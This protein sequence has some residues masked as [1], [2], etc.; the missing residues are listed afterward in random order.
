MCCN[1][2][3]VVL[4]AGG[5]DWGSREEPWDVRAG[6]ASLCIS[7]PAQLAQLA[8]PGSKPRS[9]PVH[10]IYDGTAGTKGLLPPSCSPLRGFVFGVV[11]GVF[12]SSGGASVPGMKA[13]QHHN[14]LPVEMEAGWMDGR[15]MDKRHF[16]A[17]MDLE[18]PTEL[19]QL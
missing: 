6:R 18:V 4:G 2:A 12:T 5:L 16:L 9:S 17:W 1:E 13:V 3:V 10:F 19:L 7:R 14:C 15:S 11:P 8:Q